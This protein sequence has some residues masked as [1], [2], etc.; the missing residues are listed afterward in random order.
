MYHTY[1]HVLIIGIRE[2]RGEI[3]SKNNPL[4]NPFK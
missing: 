3:L 4:I 2:I 1:L